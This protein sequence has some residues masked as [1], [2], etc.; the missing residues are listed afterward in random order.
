MKT[1]PMSQ[2]DLMLLLPLGWQQYL[3]NQ[4]TFGAYKASY[5]PDRA[6]AALDRLRAAVALP[7]DAARG[8]TAEMTRG[9]LLTQG[10]EFLEAW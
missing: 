5:T 2:S 6:A 8:A 3:D 1:F 7:D 10:R 9:E 4:P